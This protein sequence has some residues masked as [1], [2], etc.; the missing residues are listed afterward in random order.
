MQDVS[1]MHK[2]HI[3]CDIQHNKCTQKKQM[4]MHAHIC[5]NKHT[6]IHTHTHTHTS[7]YSYFSL[8]TG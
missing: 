2:M 4:S 3:T 1:H 8:F 7:Y 6:N 5:T